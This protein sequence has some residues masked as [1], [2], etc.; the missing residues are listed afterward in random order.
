MKI[1]SD[2]S[3]VSLMRSLDPVRVDARQSDIIGDEDAAATEQTQESQLFSDPVEQMVDPGAAL[4][5]MNVWA[6]A[7]YS[8]RDE[9][10]SLTQGPALKPASIVEWVDFILADKS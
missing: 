6:E 9:L 5:G 1:G 7:G 10:R 3:I 8:S 2:I 4:I